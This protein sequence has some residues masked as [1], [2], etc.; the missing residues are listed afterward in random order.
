MPFEKPLLKELRPSLESASLP[1]VVFYKPLGRDNEHP[2]YADLTSGDRHITAIIDKIRRSKLWASS[3]IFVTYDEHGGYWDHVAPP[4]GDRWGPGARVPT[5]IISPFARKDYV[6]HTVY[7]TSSILKLIETRFGIA[8]L[9][10]RD[11]DAGDLTNA[12]QF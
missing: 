9:G 2:G 3:A 8:P 5:L 6:D 1:A 12:L 7:D 10:P 11:R 4:K